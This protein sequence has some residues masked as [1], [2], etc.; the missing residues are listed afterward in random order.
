VRSAL[1]ALRGGPRTGARYLT[2]ALVAPARTVRTA[3]IAG[4]PRAYLAATIATAFRGHTA[5]P[6]AGQL[7]EVA[8]AAKDAACDRLTIEEMRGLIRR[9]NAARSMAVALPAADRVPV[10]CA[11]VRDLLEDAPSSCVALD[12]AVREACEKRHPT[13]DAHRAEAVRIIAEVCS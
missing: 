2:P 12:I 6:L 9:A 13:T 11:V 7:H 4:N 8:L 3:R 5:D 10:L 1:D